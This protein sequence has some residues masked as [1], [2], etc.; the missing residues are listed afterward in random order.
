MK[1]YYLALLLF[2]FICNAQIGVGTNSPN[3]KSVLDLTSTTKGFL[4]PRMTYAEKTAILSPPAGLQIW[5]TDCSATGELQV[6]NGTS[7][8][9]YNLIAGSLAKPN[10][11]TNVTATA[12]DSQASVAFT[13]PI[14]NGGSAIINYTVTSSP[15]S[16]TTTGSS[17]P[18]LVTGL[19]NG[20]SYTFTVIAT[21]TLGNS[22]ASS[23]S[24]AVTPKTIPDAPTSP[25]A[26][27]SN[28]Q[29]SIAFTA[30]ASNGGSA[31]TGY[32]V[33]SSPGSLTATGASSPIVFSNLNSGISYTFT[34]VA[35]NEVGN[36]AASGA[37][38]AL[39]TK[40]GAYISAGVYKVF[41]CY[42]LG[43][44]DITSDPNVPI[45]GIHGNYYQW[46]RSTAVGTTDAIIGT[47]NTTSAANGAWLDAI[48]DPC[49]SGF[50]VPTNAQ[51]LGVVN[52]AFNT[53]TRTGT[54]SDS[55]T[56]FT[57]AISF[58]TPTIKTLTLPASGSRSPTG[59]TLS[60]RGNYGIY[61][62]STENGTNAWNLRFLSSSSASTAIST[63][64]YG[65][66]VRCV[67]E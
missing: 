11:P 38:A 35:T 12:L 66:S 8:I 44:T 36:S 47:W 34:V 33:T 10:A 60:G 17:S 7:W 46:G 14:S 54:W 48:N 21:N 27:A 64:T 41:A 43:A 55:A 4:P 45:Q 53:M 1:N 2:G 37:S 52:A 24:V 19:T 26:T 23:A 6:F 16:F 3:S 32:T 42:N 56:N 57:T 25:V 67:S 62:S 5:C 65:F 40:C 28:S 20:T 50:R 49:P 18:L 22:V 39:T 30:P 9:T 61:W 29:A 31:I 51:W 59:G 13:A 58:G 63:L 15:G